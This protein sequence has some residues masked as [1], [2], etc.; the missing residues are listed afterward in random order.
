MAVVK[1]Q[2]QLYCSSDSMIDRSAL[3]RTHT[4][5]MLIVA[6]LLLLNAADMHVSGTASQSKDYFLFF[7]MTVT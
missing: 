5:E 7:S 4:K 1:W 3:S 2:Q 6:R